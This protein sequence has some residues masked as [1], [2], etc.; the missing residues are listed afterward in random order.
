MVPV[1]AT[2]DNRNMEWRVGEPVTA[3]VQLT[4]SGGDG[5]ISVPT[6]AVQTD[7]GKSVVF[8]RTKTGFQAVPVT[9]VSYTHLDVYKRQGAST[10]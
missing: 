8:V 6:T 4:G 9:S 7:E 5:A 3:S 10:G 2:L 1:I